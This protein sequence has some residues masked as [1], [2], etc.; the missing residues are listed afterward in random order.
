MDF[1]KFFRFLLKKKLILIIVPILTVVAT[2]FLVRKLPDQYTSQTDIST[3]LV[4]A[5][6]QINGINAVQD[7]KIAQ[8]FSNL[9][10]T[11]RLGKIVDQVSY[12]LILH[13]LT[14]NTS[15]AKKK[16]L[17]TLIPPAERLKAVEIFKSK[18]QKREPLNLRDPFEDK[19]HEALISL[20]YDADELR[21]KVEVNRT[22]NSDFIYV[23]YTSH[24][25]ELS[26]MVVNTLTREFIDYV[27]SSYKQNRKKTNEFLG[28]LLKQKKDSMNAKIAALREYKI[29]NRILDLS[30]LSQSLYGQITDYKDRK[31]QAEKDIL[32]Y[33]SVLRNINSRFDPK[34]RRYVEASTVKINGQISQSRQRIRALND[35]YVLSGFDESVKKSIDSLQDILSSQI[36]EMSDR[37]ISNPLAGKENLLQ[38]KLKVE[39]DLEMA[40]SSIRNLDAEL[41]RLNGQLDRIVPFEASLQSF[42]RDIEVATKEYT[43]VQN[44]YN[45]SGIESNI[46]TTLRQVE[47]AMLGDLQPSKKILLVLFSGVASFMACAAVLLVMF[48]LDNS[49]KGTTDLQGATSLKVL[50]Y[51]NL[52]KRSNVDYKRIGSDQQSTDELRLFKNLLRSIR[53]EI[54]S[55]INK[56][57]VVNGQPTSRGKILAIT[58]INE[59][60]GKS[61]VA[62]SLASAYAL[63]NKRVLIVDGNFDNPTLSESAQDK[64][65]VEDFFNDDQIVIDPLN[66]SM[67]TIFANSGGDKSLLEKSTEGVVHEKLEKLKEHFDIIIVETPAL[68]LM[69]KAKEWILFADKVL[70]V[71]EAN[72]TISSTMTTEIDYLKSL[73]NRFIG[74][75]MN[76]VVSSELLEPAGKNS[77]D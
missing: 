71:F 46:Y 36:N 23:K 34:D 53:F 1:N 70:A 61:L 27:S 74:L 33:K 26:A 58:S 51:L 8:Q 67:I 63:A 47:P 49:V 14:S 30:N 11:M 62:I 20:G 48:L 16:D 69:N 29:K 57:R 32:S 66:N 75:I 60:E 9:I 10:E 3:G 44:D 31:V 40:Q 56:D 76:K 64:I 52:I 77:K 54:D 25:P 4:D 15:F 42:E 6:Q 2:F 35:K 24:N 17:Q 65:Y 13:D 7:Y 45:Q 12:A 38:E 28:E 21:K 39:L 55:Q 37:Y 73:E 41:S 18:I 68:S 19:L 22:S 43:D 72:Q 50:G 59:G 5:S